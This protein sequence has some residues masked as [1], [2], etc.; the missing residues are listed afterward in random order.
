M[1]L[2]DSLFASLQ[3]RNSTLRI[4]LMQKLDFTTQLLTTGFKKEIKILKR[5]TTKQELTAN[6][7]QKLESLLHSKL[8]MKMILG[9][10]QDSFFMLC[11]VLMFIQLFA[12][13]S[14]ARW[15]RRDKNKTDNKTKENKGH[16][17]QETKNIQVLIPKIMINMKILKL[18]LL[19]KEKN[20]RRQKPRM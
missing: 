11:L 8:S 10:S 16:L 7:F 20:Q 12:S 4:G 18:R 15:T 6:G 19:E 17:Y 3:M 14:A 13:L 2:K 5:Q 9:F 1:T